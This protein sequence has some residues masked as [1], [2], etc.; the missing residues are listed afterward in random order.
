MKHG[1]QLNLLQKH[2]CTADKKKRRETDVQ[3]A[4]E[5]IGL[6]NEEFENWM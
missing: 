4:V 6:Q 3:Q 2:D 1:G 5:T